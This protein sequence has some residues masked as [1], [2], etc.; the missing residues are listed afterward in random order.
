MGDIY[1][2]STLFHLTENNASGYLAGAIDSD[3]IMLSLDSGEGENFPI[4]DSTSN[5]FWITIGDEILE[6]ESREYGSDDLYV[7]ERGA[8]STSAS[9]HALATIVELY[10]TAGHMDEIHDAVNDI[11]DGSVILSSVITS[12]N[13]TCGDGTGMTVIDID[14]GAGNIRGLRLQSDGVDRFALAINDTAESGSD[15]GSDL[16]FVNYDD[17]GE[18][19]GLPIIITRSSGDV[20]LSGNLSVGPGDAAASID[21]DGAAESNR[22]LYFETDNSRRWTIGANTTAETGSDAG[23]DL[24]IGAYD[25]SGVYRQTVATF[26]RATGA[27]LLAGDLDINGGSLAITN[28]EMIGFSLTGSSWTGLLIESTGTDTDPIIQLQ[29][30]TGDPWTIRND[31][32]TDNE[33]VIRHG[34][35]TRLQIDTLGNLSVKTQLF[36]SNIHNNGGTSSVGQVASGTYTPTLTA[37]TN[38]DA[39]GSP[40]GNWTRVGQV[41]NVSVRCTVDATTTGN[42]DFQVSLPVASNFA[43]AYNCMGTASI[44]SWTGPPAHIEADTTNDTAKVLHAATQTT[45]QWV[46]MTFQYVVI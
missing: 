22:R 41:V 24:L 33:F 32:S 19:L 31:E 10:D 14:G 5:A 45:T 26:T 2:M 29:A 18:S 44:G 11:E 20:T 13:I 30:K 34:G 40:K 21:I 9:S 6:I 35:N 16:L 15:A 39:M 46:Y 3:D 38:V 28:S 43:N 42:T 12:G 25:D 7:S 8:Q 37:G 36:T 27:L 23:S 1:N 17:S 4:T